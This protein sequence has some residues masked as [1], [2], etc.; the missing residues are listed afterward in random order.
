[1]S[2]LIINATILFCVL[3]INQT[4]AQLRYE[5][6]PLKV[7]SIL[8]ATSYIKALSDSLGRF[9]LIVR[10]QTDGT[11]L[12]EQNGRFSLITNGELT[13]D[14]LMALRAE[15]E[16]MATELAV[17]RIREKAKQESR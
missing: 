6:L 10:I 9:Y 4:T 3:A 14:Y 5:N 2:K 8:T 15:S 1:M 12:S 7:D 17:K 16:L 11:L 13:T